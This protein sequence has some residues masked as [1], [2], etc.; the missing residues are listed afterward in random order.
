[1]ITLFCEKK[2][3]C[4]ATARVYRDRLVSF[5]TFYQYAFV[6]NPLSVSWNGT[7]IAYEL[8]ILCVS[9]LFFLKVT[10]ICIARLRERL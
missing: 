3:N 8:Y 7:G 9:G 2:I 5:G 6:A 1:M 4:G 10:S